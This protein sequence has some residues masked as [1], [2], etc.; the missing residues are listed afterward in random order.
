MNN[1]NNTEP[2]E[3]QVYRGQVT[4]WNR[5]YGFIKNAAGKS[6]FFHTTS[7]SPDRQSKVKLLCY[8][9]YNIDRESKAQE[10]KD[11]AVNVKVL[12]YEDLARYERKMGMLRRWDGETGFIEYKGE[13][14]ALYNNRIIQRDHA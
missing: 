14:I 1:T 12:G 10:G 9:S 13:Q 2:M 11:V 6:F 5:C 3:P 8:V 7:I 4:F